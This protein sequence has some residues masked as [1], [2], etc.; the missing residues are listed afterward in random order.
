MPV[1]NSESTSSDGRIPQVSK[2]DDIKDNC[3]VTSST[4]QPAED[5]TSTNNSSS[6][7]H[8]AKEEQSAVA[9]PRMLNL[10]H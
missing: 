1:D 9:P 10:F 6:N 8:T 5:A 4:T 3:A 7:G 2:I